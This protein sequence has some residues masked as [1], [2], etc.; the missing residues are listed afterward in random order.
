MRKALHLENE[1]RHPLFHPHGVQL[2]GRQGW[3]SGTASSR[4]RPPPP[5]GLPHHP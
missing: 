2:W 1:W 4:A 3:V 5:A